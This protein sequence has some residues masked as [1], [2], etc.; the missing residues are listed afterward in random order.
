MTITPDTADAATA[1]ISRRA[2]SAARAAAARGAT[3]SCPE[4]ATKA[5]GTGPTDNLGRATIGPAGNVTP[6]A[7]VPDGTSGTI[8]ITQDG[9][10]VVMSADLLQE[11]I[12]T[13]RTKT[14]RPSPA[15]GAS[16]PGQSGKR[17]R[18]S[19]SRVNYLAQ[20]HRIME[21]AIATPATTWPPASTTVGTAAS[22]RAFQPMI[23]PVELL[24]TIVLIRALAQL[25]RPTTGVPVGSGPRLR[26][27]TTTFAAMKDAGR[28]VER[29][30][31]VTL[32]VC[33]AAR[34]L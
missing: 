27:Q 31:P 20:A 10:L 21:T 15:R 1:R 30:V 19:R 22:R 7:A 14:S 23:I 18:P 3:L 28:A 33:H 29:A 16:T 26:T 11:C 4:P 25:R 9:I 32:K 12:S 17:T 13:T 6:A 34:Q 24:G 5:A 2:S 8:Q